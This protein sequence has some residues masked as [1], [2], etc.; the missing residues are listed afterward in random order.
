MKNPPCFKR[1][2]QTWSL[3]PYSEGEEE[4]CEAGAGEAARA[5]VEAGL[6][7]AQCK[8]TSRSPRVFKAFVFQPF[9]SVC[10]STG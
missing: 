1:W 7:E 9:Q 6:G 10:V 4:E 2:F 3:H 5:R 8:L